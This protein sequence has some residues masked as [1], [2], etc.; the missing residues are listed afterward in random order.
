[1]AAAKEKIKKIVCQC[2]SPK[3]NNYQTC[4]KGYRYDKNGW[5]Y[6]H[7]EGEP[8]ERGEQYGNLVADKYIKILEKTKYMTYQTTGVS[9]E[10][11]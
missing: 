3:E 7:I 10:P 6:V 8:E 11:A 9:Y 2:V 5:T 1:L 4:D